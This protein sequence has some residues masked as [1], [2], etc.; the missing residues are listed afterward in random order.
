M[1]ATEARRRLESKVQ[2]NAAPTLTTAEI[3]ELLT[4][5]RVTDAAGVLPDATG[6]VVTYSERGVNRAA[7]EGWRW[8]AGKVADQYDLSSTGGR[9]LARSQ[10]PE[11]C[12]LMAERFDA[13][14]RG[15]IGV[16]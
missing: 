3:T 13:K 9:K 10:T 14:A 7:A 8:K 1:D 15:G 16:I 2:L 5:A 4:G 12:L 6:Y 11:F